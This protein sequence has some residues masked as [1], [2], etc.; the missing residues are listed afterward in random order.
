MSLQDAEIQ[1]EDTIERLRRRLGPLHSEQIRAWQQ[2][3]PARRLEL[4]CQ[5]YHTALQIVRLRERAEHPDLTEA[6]LDWRIT[7]RMQGDWRLGR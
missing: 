4:A 6:E 1:A 7:R 2:M 5:A 3:S